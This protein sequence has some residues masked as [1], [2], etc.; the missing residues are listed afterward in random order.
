MNSVE[1]N[2]TNFY[3]WEAYGGGKKLFPWSVALEPPLTRRKTNLASHKGADD[4]RTH[5]LFSRFFQAFTSPEK[6][7]AEIKEDLPVDNSP[8]PYEGYQ[9]TEPVYEL[10]LSPSPKHTPS[11]AE[12]E[13]FLL[14]A[15][16]C[17]FPLSFEIFI[18]STGIAF[19]F[20]GQKED[21]DSLYYQLKSYFPEVTATR[22]TNFLTHEA[23]NPTGI[24]AIIELAPQE[25][26]T[27]PIK[28]CQSL[29]PDSLVGIL[30]ACE[31]ASER[32]QE[33]EMGLI[34]VLFQGVRQR[35]AESI[36]HAVSDG[37]GGSFF[38]DSQDMLPLAREKTKGPLFSAVIRCVGQGQDGEQAVNILADL[39]ESFV[40][41]DNPG[42]NSLAFIP[43]EGYPFEAHATNVALRQTNRPGMILSSRELVNLVHIPNPAAVT[44]KLTQSIRKTKAAPAFAL[45]PEYALGINEHRGKTN[46]VGLS[47]AQLSRHVL[48]TGS[49][50][51]GKSVLLLNLAIQ[52]IMNGFGGAIIDPHGD[53]VED[54]ISQIPPEKLDNVIVL[55]PTNP[56]FS[57]GLNLLNAQTEP[58]KIQLSS[59]MAASLTQQTTNV[60]PQMDITL[61]N[62][63]MTI[64]ESEKEGSLLDLWHFLKDE[65]VRN[66]F[67]E[68]VHD[69]ILLSFWD[70]EFQRITK[71]T[72]SSLLNRLQM[73][74]RP[75]P[76][77]YMLMQK[78]G[79][80]FRKIMD[81]RKVLLIKLSLGLLGEQNSF[82][83]GS[84][85]LTKL[86]QAA[87]SRQAISRKER[88][89][90]MVGIDEFQNFVTP[91]LE[92][93]LSGARK[94]GLGLVLAHQNLDQVMRRSA[95]V[96]NSLLANAGTRICFG[97]GDADAAKFAAGFSGFEAHDLVSL[98][99]GEAVVRIGGRQHD[100][101]LSTQLPEAVPDDEAQRRHQF[102]IRE[103]GQ[104]YGVPIQTLEEELRN[105]KVESTP[106]KTPKPKV[107]RGQKIED[108]PPS[109]PP[110]SHDAKQEVV[111]DKPT[112]KAVEE[113]APVEDIET[114]KEAFLKANRRKTE[115]TEH[116]YLQTLIKKMAEA[117]GF[118]ATIEKPTPDGHGRVDVALDNGK[119]KIACEV[120]V[121]TTP[122]HEL[123]NIQKCLKAGFDHIVACSKR[124]K[125]LAKIKALATEALDQKASKKVHFFQPEALFAFLDQFSAQ[126]AS[127]EKRIKGY[128]V[129]TNY[130]PVAP[131]EG[132]QK[133]ED[134]S[135]AILDSLNR[136]KKPKDK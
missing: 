119:I 42:S 3:D 65:G 57:I 86:Y 84:L 121:T 100:F 106:T 19:Q 99:T 96:G 74:L 92:G 53:L 46:L 23:W 128:R 83:L 16:E 94:Y 85:I 2:T 68:S 47:S 82:S 52:C 28:L 26:F 40:V 21:I 64:L 10:V 60:G 54:I 108:K 66:E 87:L 135:K 118:K 9:L 136:E 61:Q 45:N 72:M 132:K 25:E 48:F 112:A 124:P 14:M 73:F 77:R 35:W 4:G 43:N 12:A 130:N 1:R 70:D 71:A 13:A 91:T 32:M 79:L 131:G 37:S 127:G 59:D 69:P 90:F 22:Q 129:K 76:L 8:K 6:F 97:V 15:G 115:H 7:L 41:L 80:D 125:H 102:V 56:D 20:A 134:I 109:E 104:K 33:G 95:S 38:S 126:Q 30:A 78:D 18:L 5:T 29:N 103:S 107:T 34:Q 62:A 101:S 27:R 122:E 17:H 88:H 55:D 133:H 11:L 81:E 114:A 39:V 31:R 89:M 93:I 117:K 67:L 123:G 24:T 116:Q 75:K 110:I 58:E 111:E 50:G 51:K 113:A 105:L 49:T 63:I 98:N 44:S 36:L 120:S